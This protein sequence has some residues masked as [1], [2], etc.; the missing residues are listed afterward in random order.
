MLVVRILGPSG[1]WSDQRQVC[2]KHVSVDRVLDG[3]ARQ[4]SLSAFAQLHGARGRDVH[5]ERK[6]EAVTFRQAYIEI[7]LHLR[8][9][10]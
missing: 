6:R 9:H 5:L 1:A 8:Q 7:A 3:S 4:D 10:I 2:T